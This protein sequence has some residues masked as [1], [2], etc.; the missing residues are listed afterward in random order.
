MG[1]AGFYMTKLNPVLR[2]LSIVVGLAML[3]PGIRSDI[4]G[5]VFFAAITI[6]QLVKSKRAQDA[7]NATV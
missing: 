7:V 5:Y 3:Y 2:I 4:I 1:V 6:Y